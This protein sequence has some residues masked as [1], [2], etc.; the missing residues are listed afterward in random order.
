MHADLP[1]ESQQVME[2][3]VLAPIEQPIMPAWSWQ[4]TTSNYNGNI[5]ENSS[6]NFDNRQLDVNTQMWT[7]P[8][9][10]FSFLWHECPSPMNMHANG[11]G[12]AAE[13]LSDILQCV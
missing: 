12:N 6:N 13:C 8:T 7:D 9:V 10:D 5:G 11:D 4:P 2:Q 3:P 1:L